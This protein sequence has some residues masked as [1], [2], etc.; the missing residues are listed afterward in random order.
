MLIRLIPVPALALGL[1]CTELCAASAATV[2]DDYFLSSLCLNPVSGSIESGSATLASS[3]SESA[4]YTTRF[5]PQSW[6]GELSKERVRSSTGKTLL[7][8]AGEQFP[9]RRALKIASAHTP[10]GLTEFTWASLSEQQRQDLNTDT[11]GHPD[12]FGAARVSRL[13]GEPCDDLSGCA[14]LR[15]P[16]RLG[17]SIHARPISVAQPSHRAAIMEKYDGPAGA[18]AA[19]KAQSRRTQLYL[20]AND[21]TLHAFDAQ[22]GEE[23]LAFLPSQSLA[24]LP[25]LTSPHYTTAPNQHRYFVDGRLVADDVFYR[26][27]WHTVLV[28][29][30]GAGGRGLFALDITDPD[31]IRLLWEFN[32]DSNDDLGYTLGTPSIARLHNG[33]W[34]AVFGNGQDSPA[35]SASLFLVEIETGTLIKRLSVPPPAS[36]LGMPLLADTNGDGNADYAY[37]GD[38][39]GN[40]WRFDLYDYRRESLDKAAPE[41]A[42]TAER[43]RLSFGGRPLFS[44]AQ[45]RPQPISSA[46]TIVS[47]PSE[48]GYLI[49][50]GTGQ[51]HLPDAAHE[52]GPYTLYGIWDRHIQGQNAQAVDT[53]RFT[54]LQ[55]QRLQFTSADDAQ[56]PPSGLSRHPITWASD[57]QPHGKLGWYLDLRPATNATSAER[58]LETPQR[59]GEL[60][61]VTTRAPSTAPCKMADALRLYAIDPTLGGRAAQNVFD[62]NGDGQ[63][64]ELDSTNGLAPSSISTQP[65][66]LIIPNAT[67]GAPCLLGD[68]GCLAL[69]LGPRANGRQSWRVVFDVAP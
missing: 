56:A 29:S 52:H 16:P 25:A 45:R 41:T 23:R 30:L 26:G 49:I 32:G 12:G 65:P 60:L 34:A 31:R 51:N 38:N 68:S 18:Y 43:F 3:P 13:R 27:A 48:K 40:L 20:G 66:W 1:V 4:L 42:S 5:F 24:R 15:S 53:V 6:E 33:Q 37:A 55:Q 2:A 47:H 63:V 22:T 44:A 62:I 59:L 54:D 17:D 58:L 57:S 35:S 36:A 61:L 7:W 8:K 28:G 39:Q 50:T 11:K 10:S 64:N 9:T 14:A 67:G 69:S 46:P 19:F 21:G